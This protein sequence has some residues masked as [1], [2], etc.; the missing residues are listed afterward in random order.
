MRA[1]RR[2]GRPADNFPIV[3]MQKDRGRVRKVRSASGMLVGPSHLSVRCAHDSW[4]GVGHVA[5][6][7]HRQEFDFQL[8]QYDD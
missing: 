8:T 4:S 6:C 2:K 7:M 5:V 1:R 3:N